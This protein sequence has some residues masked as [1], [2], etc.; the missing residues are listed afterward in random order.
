EHPLVEK[1]CRPEQKTEVKAFVNKMK[2]LNE[3]A[4][5]ST[6][7]EKEGVFTGA[8]AINPMD[9]SRIP[10][11]LANYVLMDYGTGA[12]MAVPAHDQRD[13]EFARK[14]DIPIKVVIKGEDI[15]LD[16]N[17]LQES[18]PGDGHMVN[19]GE[20]DGLIVEE[21]QKAV[22]KFMEEKGIGRGTIN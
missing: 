11:W 8:Y 13:F 14:Y 10:I 3:M 22:I 15:P 1:I 20:F 6:E 4:R 16:G 17:L 9:G 18:Y 5:T 7:A 12:I 2:Y 21:G 19:S